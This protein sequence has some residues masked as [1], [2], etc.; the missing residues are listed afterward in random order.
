MAG[1]A[2]FILKLNFIIMLSYDFQHLYRLKGEF[3]NGDGFYKKNHRK[4]RLCR[5]QR[6]RVV[7]IVLLLHD[8]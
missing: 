6:T 8:F 4:Y 7:M 1:D 5:G 2:N 3:N